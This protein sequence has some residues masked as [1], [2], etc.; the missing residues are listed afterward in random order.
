[1]RSA[2]GARPSDARWIKTPAEDSCRYAS[3]NRT[4]ERPGCSGA[5]IST[6]GW[7][8]SSLPGSSGPENRTHSCVSHSR[9]HG[10]NAP[11]STTDKDLIK[12]QGSLQTD[13]AL[14]L[15][16]QEL[17]GERHQRGAIYECS[18]GRP[19]HRDQRRRQDG[20]AAIVH[21]DDCPR[22]GHRIVVLVR[23]SVQA[24]RTCGH[25]RGE[26]DEAGREGRQERANAELPTNGGRG[27]TVQCWV[28]L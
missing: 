21:T 23:G 17:P 27:S 16:S 4:P 7:S 6:R 26:G 25:C 5:R 15:G 18:I 20:E 24:E 1:M 28:S 12:R 10:D 19:F 9:L 11:R 13:A 3:R 8:P 22:I 2:P 14:S